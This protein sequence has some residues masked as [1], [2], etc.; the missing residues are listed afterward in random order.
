MNG[1][2]VMLPFL[3]VG[4]LAVVLAHWPVRDRQPEDI[5]PLDDMDWR[6]PS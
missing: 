6:W 3:L 4:L 2:E 1:L 5:D